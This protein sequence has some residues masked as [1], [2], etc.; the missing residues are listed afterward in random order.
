ML[1]REIAEKSLKCDALS[2]KC[3]ELTEARDELEA[4]VAAKQVQYEEVAE[5]ESLIQV[6]RV[7]GDLTRAHRSSTCRRGIALNAKNQRGA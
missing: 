7:E 4:A 5:S 2:K 3:D 6:C 1:S